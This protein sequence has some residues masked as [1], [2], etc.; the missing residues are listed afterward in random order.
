M[1]IADVLGNGY[2]PQQLQHLAELEAQ[3]IDSMF[4]IL[5]D[6]QMEK[7]MVRRIFRNSLHNF[8]YM[9]SGARKIA[10]FVCRI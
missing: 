9:E 2:R 1:G 4:I 10:Y 5:S 7:P 8:T 6:I 3:S